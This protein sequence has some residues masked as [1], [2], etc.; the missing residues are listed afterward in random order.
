MNIID[1]LP[2]ILE[3]IFQYGIFAALFILLLGAVLYF[4]WIIAFKI[5]DHTIKTMNSI[6]ATNEKF[7]ESSG[8]MAELVKI[9]ADQTESTLNQLKFI[10]SNLN[11][12]NAAATEL[13][14]IIR[15][16]PNDIKPEISI[17]LDNIIKELQR[18]VND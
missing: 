7:A 16:I 8:K 9:L 14:Q 5:S 2:I 1:I 3:K 13:I 15:L 12:Q 17:R 11:R 18:P 6:S 4:V 10:K